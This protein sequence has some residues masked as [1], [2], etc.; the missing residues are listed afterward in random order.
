MSLYV[1]DTDVLS[2][3]QDGHPA[4]VT[5]SL[6]NLLLPLPEIRLQNSAQVA[7]RVTR[8]V[9]L[10]LVLRWRHDPPPIQFGGHILPQSQQAVRW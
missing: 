10:W 5:N 4:V 1:L 6:G 9:R 2:P 3:V 7:S 8:P